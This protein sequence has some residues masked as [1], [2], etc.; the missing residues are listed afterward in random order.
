MRDTLWILG[1]IIIL[2]KRGNAKLSAMY[3]RIDSVVYNIQLQL[4]MFAANEDK[5]AVFQK[6]KR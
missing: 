2:C 6:L 1:L 3:V 4:Q 5:S